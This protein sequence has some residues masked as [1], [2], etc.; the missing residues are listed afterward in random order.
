MI[1][2]SLQISQDFTIEDIHKV[3]EKNYHNTKNMTE[4]EKREYYNKRGMEVHHAIQKI[5]L[6]RE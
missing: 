3:R 1:M 4:Q 2:K 6:E 5:K